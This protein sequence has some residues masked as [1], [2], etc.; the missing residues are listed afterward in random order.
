[1]RESD[2]TIIGAG[3]AGMTAA[4]FLAKNKIPVTLLEKRSFPRDKIC[5]DCIGG[6][7]L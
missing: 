7:G 1:M 6:F 2:V 3:P 4:F 5:G